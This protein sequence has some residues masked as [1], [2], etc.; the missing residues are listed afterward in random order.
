MDFSQF[1]DIL[2]EALILTAVVVGIMLLVDLVR[3][4]TANLADSSLWKNRRWTV[5]MA[6]LLGATPGCI[7]G[8]VTVSLYDRRVV[9][10][11]AIIAMA[12]ATMGDETFIMLAM[13]P[14]TA[15]ALIGGLAA[16]GIITGYACDAVMKD[17]Y[18]HST[19]AVSAAEHGHSGWKHSL[20]HALKVSAWALCAM[21]A[22]KIAG[23][24]IDLEP[25]VSGNAAVLVAIA[26]LIGLIPVSGPHMVFVTLFAQGM[27]P[28]PVLLASCIAQEGHAGLP[29]LASD[30]KAF[31]RMK[32]I[33]CMLALAAGWLGLLFV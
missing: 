10:F 15:L 4:N 29:L 9:S 18:S 23:F 27:L 22:I 32:L 14:K 26:A 13:F 30:R 25:L 31:I 1:T 20:L 3:A 28:L 7:G 6:A 12:M 17:R 11:G 33:K 8:Y 21:L 5:P 16:A 19:E 2:K 24:Y